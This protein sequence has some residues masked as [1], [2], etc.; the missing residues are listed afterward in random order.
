[1]NTTIN[2]VTPQDYLNLEATIREQERLLT[3]ELF[4][5]ADAWELGQTL[6]RR[7]QEQSID[8][9]AAIYRP[10]GTLMFA[11]LTRGTGVSNHE[12]MRRKFN[13]VSACGHSSLRAWARW[14]SSEPTPLIDQLAEDADY[15]VCGGGFPIMTADGKLLAVALV[16]ALPH[17]QDHYFLSEA[18]ADWCG[19]KIPSF[20]QTIV[21]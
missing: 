18:L 20:D 15:A 9:A 1:M 19:T 10:N 11:Y 2:T 12:W 4:D 5:D 16:S 17:A 21:D 14:K 8:L 7:I 6:V 3:V 13:T